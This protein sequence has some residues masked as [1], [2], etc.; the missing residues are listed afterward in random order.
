MS[1]K[2]KE[3]LEIRAVE[4]EWACYCGLKFEV[5][6]PA[7]LD[8][9]DEHTKRCVVYQGRFAA[10][11][12]EKPDLHPLLPTPFRRPKPATSTVSAGAPRL[13]KAA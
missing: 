7:Q 8:V 2:R 13:R 4:E 11:E 3:K 9:R 5:K 6:F 10:L 1:L 12:E